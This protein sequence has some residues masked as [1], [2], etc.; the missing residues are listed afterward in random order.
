MGISGERYSLITFTNVHLVHHVHPRSRFT[1]ETRRHGEQPR[2][3]PFSNVHK[4]HNVHSTFAFMS[5]QRFQS[6]ATCTFQRL[7]SCG[8]VKPNRPIFNCERASAIAALSGWTG[9]LQESRLYCPVNMESAS[10]ARIKS[11]F[12]IQARVSEKVL[13]NQQRDAAYTRPGRRDDLLEPPA[14]VE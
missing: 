1:T 6:N 7:T 5:L 14:G 12:F 2:M 13:W 3:K 8:S 9:A 11:S 4:V 10:I